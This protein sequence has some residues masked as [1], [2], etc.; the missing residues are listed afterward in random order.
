MQRIFNAPRNSRAAVTVICSL[1]CLAGAAH[2][3]EQNAP[4]SDTANST[5]TKSTTPL[6]DSV[7]A[8]TPG[9]ATLADL[10]EVPKQPTAPSD[11]VK[12][13]Q[14]T[15]AAQGTVVTASG[16][17]DVI[18]HYNNSG[19]DHSELSILEAE[20]DLGA[21]LSDKI[22]LS[23]SIT[24]QPETRSMELTWATASFGLYTAPNGVLTNV[25][26]TAGLFNPA[27]G[28]DCRHNNA[29]CR[30]LATA[31]IVVQLT[32]QGW[33]DVGVQFDLENAVGNFS[34]YI[35]NGFEPAE[36]VQQDVI[37]LITG[38][39][40]STVPAPANAFGARL[41]LVPFAGLEIGGSAAVGYNSAGKDDMIMAGADITLEISEFEIRSEYISHSISRSILQSDNSGYYIQPT[42]TAGKIFV[43]ARYDSFKAEG[44][45]RIKGYTVG[46]GYAVAENVELRLETKLA[47]HNNENKTTMQVVAGF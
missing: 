14:S 39:G 10:G 23:S 19:E 15:P 6:F 2:T 9:P 22:E 27:F 31:P 16:F 41:G 29:L 1:L 13:V 5:I 11:P 3:A 47:D 46:A 8:V 35:V 44:Y 12:V 37:N 28:L 33:A 34:A 26:L 36:E 24:L 42:Y 4:S 17:L 7:Q 25:S 40:D 38:L 45:E 21:T 32:H 18:G 20:V 43:T 30:K